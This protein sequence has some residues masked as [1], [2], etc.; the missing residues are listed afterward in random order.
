LP[1]SFSLLFIASGVLFI[2]MRGFSESFVL[3]SGDGLVLLASFIWA[4]G[5]LIFRKF[6]HS[7]PVSTVVF[8]RSLIAVWGIALT[9]LFSPAS[10]VLAQAQFLTP[11]LLVTLLAFAFLSRFLTVFFFYQSLD[12]LP[13]ATVSV[14]SNFAVVGSILFASWYLGEPLRLY[15]IIGA[16]LILTGTVLLEVFNGFHPSHEHRVAHLMQKHAHRA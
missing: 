15:Q 4:A 2:T 12:R 16:S 6:L 11:D 8:T 1:H 10:V 7:V 3:Q 14:F 5:G 9:F 13:V